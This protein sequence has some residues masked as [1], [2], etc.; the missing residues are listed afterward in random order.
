MKIILFLTLAFT[1][2]S[3]AKQQVQEPVPVCPP[4]YYSINQYTLDVFTSTAAAC[5]ATVSEL[6]ETY[7]AM[8][9]NSD[10][11]AVVQRSSGSC[12]CTRLMSLKGREFD[13]WGAGCNL[14]C[15]VPIT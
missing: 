13:R 9:S 1:Q 7:D 14:N 4:G 6:L 8:C 2:Y 15:C 12:N 5:I 10:P 11:D 3:N